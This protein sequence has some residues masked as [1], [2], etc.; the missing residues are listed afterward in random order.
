MIR[1]HG[2]SELCWARLLRA[3]GQAQCRQAHS[4]AIVCAKQQ[5]SKAGWFCGRT[6]EALLKFVCRY[7]PAVCL[8]HRGCSVMAAALLGMK[9]CSGVLNL[10][11]LDNSPSNAANE[12]CA[13]SAWPGSCLRSTQ[14]CQL[15]RLACSKR[16]LIQLCSCW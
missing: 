11:C 5:Q 6:S 12:V 14:G 2:K 16:F 1:A 4:E 10:L 9:A 13:V 3:L 8:P 15:S 7:A